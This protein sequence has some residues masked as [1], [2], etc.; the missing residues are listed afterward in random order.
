[1]SPPRGRPCAA[2]LPATIVTLRVANLGCI[3]WVFSCVLVSS[4]L[5]HAAGKG[6]I[7]RESVCEEREERARAC[8]S[9][10]PLATRER[11]NVCVPRGRSAVHNTCSLA[12]RLSSLCTLPALAATALDPPPAMHVFLFVE[13][14]PEGRGPITTPRLPRHLQTRAAVDGRGRAVHRRADDCG[15]APCRGDLGA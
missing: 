7:N 5:R 11:Q 2:F 12:I 4:G 10:S 3:V 8:V 6:A 1:M 13:T 14:I 15:T 9:V